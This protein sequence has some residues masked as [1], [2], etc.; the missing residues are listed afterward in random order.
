MPKKYSLFSRSCRRIVRFIGI[1]LGIVLGGVS[2]RATPAT[3]YGYPLPSIYA[4]SEYYTLTVN[5]TNIPVVNYTAQYDYAEFSMSGGTAT[6]QVTAPTQSGITSYGISPQKLGLTGT[7]NGNTLTFSISGSQYLIVSING[8]KPF[9]LC[10]DPAETNVPLSSGTGIFN[11]LAAPY[12][13]DNTGSTKTSA[14]IQSAINAASA[15][16][17]SNRPGI[18]YVPAGVYLCGNLALESN[19]ALYL[20]GG[21]VIRCTG[22]PA[23]Y[24]TGDGYRGSFANVVPG[25][26]VFLSAANGT[27]IKIYGRGTVDGNG[28]YMGLTNNFGDNLLIPINCTN[29]TVDG[30]T[31]RDAGGWA[32][33]PSES[34][35]V[36]FSNL[37][38]FDNLSCAQDD[39]ID[40][41][42][43]QSVTVSN[44]FGIAGDDT[45]STKSYT[46]A[47]SNILFEDCLL[48]SQYIACKTG[49]EVDV[50][51][52]DITYSNIVV[53]NCQNGVGLAEYKGGGSGGSTVENL[54][55][56]ALDV[57]N[58]TQGTPA[59]QAW[60]WFQ[61]QT[62]N[63]LAT[64]VLVSNITV[65]QSGLNGCIGGL[66]SNAII[67]GITFDNIYMPGSSTPASNLY[68]MNIFNQQFYTNLTILPAQAPVPAVYLT[69]DDPNGSTSFNAAGNWSDGLAPFPATNYVVGSF[70]LRT[71]TSGNRTFAGNSLSLYDAATLALKNDNSTTTVGANP[72]TGLF[73]DNS[74]VKNVDAANDTLAGYVTLLPNGGIF[75]MPA[76]TGYTFTISAAIG[77][78]GAFQAGTSGNAGTIKLSGL[79]T[80]S[81]GTSFGTTFSNFVTLQLSG[82]GTLGSNSGP[83]TFNSTNDILD[84]NGTSQGVGNLSGPAGTITNSAASAGT[85]TIGN[86]NNGGGTFSGAIVKGNGTIAL[87]KAGS[88][89]ITLSGTN[90]YTGNT[91]VIGGTLALSGSG[92]IANSATITLT[93]GTAL[94]VSGRTD[95]TLT[96][97]SGQTLKG[98]GSVNGYLTV[99]SGATVMPGNTTGNTMGTLTVQNN[100][101]LK[102]LLLMELNRTNAPT[103]GQLVS[104][105]GSITGGGTLTV[106]NLGPAMQ[107]G[108]T[109]Q[110]FSV[111]ASGFSSVT[112]PG[113]A[114]GLAWAAN[115]A[116]NGTIRVAATNPTNI[117]AQI[118]A[119][120]LT[121]SWPSNY[122]GWGL[123]EQ[124]NLLGSNWL[125]V[126]GSSASNQITIPIT[127][128]TPAAFFRLIYP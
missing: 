16:G 72:A 105:V 41:V 40:V 98:S 6:L 112:L 111:P 28:T 61:I 36:T 64:N 115:L 27:N 118:T 31:F 109:F 9:A 26:T 107:A 22:N 73:L 74:L 14:A 54:T 77:G 25:G 119:N 51:Q 126:A 34:A 7:T 110:L 39:C 45:L 85:L 113:L 81:G 95:Q 75:Q 76:G 67:N 8:L 49:W 58:T 94:D 3:I 48:W 19:L 47:I 117:T 86:G 108:D 93:N 83:L 32:L 5:G 33:V 128:A 97:N 121:L 96:L 4:N 1:V 62:T 106:T 24:A 57:E 125:D 66:Y 15:Y 90:T 56:E 35:D 123:Q 42:D 80:Y 82:S 23:D 65:R 122:T 88:G 124:T 50:P 10:A 104:T 116:V 63:G 89:T 127:P 18:V 46:Y 78:S 71:P 59:S 92:S 43:S 2:A 91:T 12:N 17:N 52:Y 29:F 38:I 21:S 30:I 60:G 68:Q 79:N 102:G 55:F 20:Q 13:A 100:V 114:P 70:T 103:S 37:K 99:L 84:L 44:V 101:T 120:S 87:N 53:Y 69:A 11:V